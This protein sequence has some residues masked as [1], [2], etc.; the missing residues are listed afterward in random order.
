[1][2]PKEWPLVE[3]AAEKFRPCAGPASL[4]RLGLSDHPGADFPI[5]ALRRA[6]L[7]EAGKPL[8]LRPNVCE[9]PA[10]RRAGLIEAHPLKCA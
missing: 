5:P 7:I 4:K 9:I 10:L 1:M 2:K 6:G 3:L 8:L